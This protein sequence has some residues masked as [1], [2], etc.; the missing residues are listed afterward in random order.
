VDTLSYKTISANANTVDKQWLVVDVAG[1]PLGRM[2]S[3]VA[4]IIRGK[5]NP[6]I[7]LT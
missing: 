5:T 6:I 3:E 7:L 4:K 1:M 2:A